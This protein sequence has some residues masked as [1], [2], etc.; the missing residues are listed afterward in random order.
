[1]MNLEFSVETIA[2]FFTAITYLFNEL[3]KE[4]LRRRAKKKPSSLAKNLEIDSEIYPVLWHLMLRY[5]CIRAYITQFHNGDN[6]YTGQSIQRETV[7]HEVVA[8]STVTKIKPFRDN[9]LI[10]YMDHKIL[11]EI[12]E[13]S[14]FSFGLKWHAQIDENFY[15]MLKDW[16]DLYSV[17]SLLYLP[18]KNRQGNIV[19]IL[20]MHWN[21]SEAINRK[22]GL[23]IQEQVTL[24]E[25]VFNRIKP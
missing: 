13:H 15:H 16:T 3:R 21:F 18:I 14:Q 9:V 5:K 1:M 10:T 17:R 20:N 6:F 19:A 22:H 2:V 24:L 25:T 11:V 4:I 7:S 12:K 23:E 8:D